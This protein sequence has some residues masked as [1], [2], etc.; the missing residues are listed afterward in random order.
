MPQSTV[1][2]S[3]VPPSA[4]CGPRGKTLA[5][6]P[7]VADPNR[8]VAE[9]EGNNNGAPKL[10][11]EAE[12]NNNAAPKQMA[13]VEGATLSS[14]KQL[15]EAEGNTNQA[16]SRL[17]ESESVSTD[18]NSTVVVASANGPSTSRVCP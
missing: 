5:T 18:R 1:P 14:R 15:A 10:M 6:G 17:A 8:K 2:L 4:E 9:A 11:A 12:G 16:R 3:T 13:E 7:G